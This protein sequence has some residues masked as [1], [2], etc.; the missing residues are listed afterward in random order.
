MKKLELT[1]MENLKG[2]SASPAGCFLSGFITVMSVGLS[3][4]SGSSL[5]NYQ[6]SARCWNS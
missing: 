5:R 1:Q 4:F 6:Y 2:G 3:T